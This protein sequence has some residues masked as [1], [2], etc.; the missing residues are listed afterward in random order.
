MDSTST[1]MHTSNRHTDLCEINFQKYRVDAGTQLNTLRT[2]NGYGQF[3]ARFWSIQTKL[4]AH[5]SPWSNPTSRLHLHTFLKL[6][7]I[8]GCFGVK[9]TK[10]WSISVS[11]G[12]PGTFWCRPR[13]IRRPSGTSSD[14][15]NPWVQY[16]HTKSES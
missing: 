10:V 4:R 8:F 11:R 16:A 9:L 5:T 13:A 1:N 6:R 14:Y 12:R 15:K 3:G 7:S 2:K